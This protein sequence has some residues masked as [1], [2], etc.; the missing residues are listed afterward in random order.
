[1]VE[2]YDIMFENVNIILDSEW[3]QENNS[4]TL[5]IFCI[6]FHKSIVG[7]AQFLQGVFSKWLV[8]SM[9]GKHRKQR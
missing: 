4:F 8:N 7:F 9:L 2:T 5:F 6:Q 1:M 3:I